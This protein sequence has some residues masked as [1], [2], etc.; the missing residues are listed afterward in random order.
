MKITLDLHG[1]TESAIVSAMAKELRRRGWSVEMPR[2]WETPISFRLLLGFKHDLHISDQ[3]LARRMR[4]PRCP[5]VEVERGQKGRLVRLASNPA[6]EKF[7]L[8]N[9]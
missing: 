4:D 6:F 2:E 9:L 7:V 3:H 1:V 8:Q 5:H